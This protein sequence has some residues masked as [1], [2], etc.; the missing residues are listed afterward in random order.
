[1]APIRRFAAALPL[2]FL[3]TSRLLADD[4]G[5]GPT[6]AD[7]R[8]GAAIASGDPGPELRIDFENVA[9]TRKSLWIAG[10]SGGVPEVGYLFDI[11]AVGGPNGKE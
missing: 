4:V 5:W 8:L 2:L 11:Y 10:L 9:H 6:V 7:L 3:G 1:M